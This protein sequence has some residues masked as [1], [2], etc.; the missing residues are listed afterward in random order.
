MKVEETLQVMSQQLAA[1]TTQQRNPSVRQ[2]FRCEKPGHLARNCRSGLSQAE[3]FKCG[4]RG[5]LTRDCWSQGNAN[6]G[7]PT[8]RAGS[9]PRP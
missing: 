4:R 1:P 3:C 2:C 9:T 7:A 8:H 6:G 5:H